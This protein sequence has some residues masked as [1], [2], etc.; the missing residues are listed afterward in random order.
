[1]SV[2]LN[3]TQYYDQ[4]GAAQCDSVRRSQRVVT[5]SYYKTAVT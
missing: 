2:T 5:P 4:A 1:M 3:K